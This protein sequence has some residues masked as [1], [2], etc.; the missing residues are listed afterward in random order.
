MPKGGKR[1]LAVGGDLLTDRLR[2]LGPDHPDTL[3]TRSNLA[4]WSRAASDVDKRSRGKTACRSADR[5]SRH[6]FRDHRV[7]TLCDSSR[8]LVPTLPW[9]MR[10]TGIAR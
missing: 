1:R 6:R 5:E 8:R 2:V 10:R 9:F 3:N 4:Y 7:V